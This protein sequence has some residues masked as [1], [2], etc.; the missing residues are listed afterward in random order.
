MELNDGSAVQNTE[1]ADLR[2]ILRPPVLPEGFRDRLLS[3]MAIESLQSPARDVLEQDWQIAQARLRAESVELRWRTLLWLLGGA[4]AAG[5]VTLAAVPWVATH[6]GGRWSIWVPVGVASLGLVVS[7]A[8]DPRVRR[9][10]AS[11]GIF[12]A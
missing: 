5:A 11:G 8:G 1:A 9:W 6:L 12:G 4:F 10:L 3:R 7:W 2:S